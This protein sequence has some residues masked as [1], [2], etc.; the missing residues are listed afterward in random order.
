M[1]PYAIF[2]LMAGIILLSYAIGVIVAAIWPW[3]LGA[4]VV[5]VVSFILAAWVS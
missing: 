3:L 5:A 2:F 4:L 1:M